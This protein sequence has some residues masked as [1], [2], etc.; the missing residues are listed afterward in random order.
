MKSP[1][2]NHY[3]LLVSDIFQHQPCVHGH[4]SR[5]HCLHPRRWILLRRFPRIGPTHLEYFFEKKF[6]GVSLGHL[7]CE[8]IYLNL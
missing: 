8:H 4:K 5:R 1:S 7:N 6:H 3:Y 2:L